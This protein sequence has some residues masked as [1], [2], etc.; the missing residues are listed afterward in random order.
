MSQL[1]KIRYRLFAW[2][3]FPQLQSS[4]EAIDVVIPIVGKDLRILPLCLEGVYHCVAHPIQQIYIVAPAQDEIVCFCEEHGLQFVDEREVFGF[5]PKDL[6][7]QIQNSDG[8]QSNRSGWLFQQLIKLSGRVGTCQHYLCIDAD[9]VLIR[10]HVFLTQDNK[11]V[12]YM[13]YEE[14]QPY[15]DNIHRLLPDLAFDKLSYVDH[16]MLFDKQQVERLHQALTQGTGLSWTDVVL[17]SYD[18]SSFAGFSEF[19]LYG[20]FVVDK[21]QRPWLQKRLPYKKMA[22]YDT[23][24]RQWSRSRWS[25]TFPD[26]MRQ[27]KKE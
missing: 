11:T 17:K 18:R 23:L 1:R 2:K 27:N 3:R 8:S 9:H 21:V 5:G 12:F 7:L 26:Y 4:A 24:Q 10:P 20:N 19:E 16:K 14:H 15:Y 22:D 25:L 13:S 6:N